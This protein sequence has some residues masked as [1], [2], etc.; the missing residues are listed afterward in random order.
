MKTCQNC[1]AENADEI[2]HCLA[3]H[4]EIIER[5]T[6]WQIIRETH[7]IRRLESK[8]QQGTHEIRSKQKPAAVDRTDESSVQTRPNAFVTA[9]ENLEWFFVSKDEKH[10]PVTAKEIQEKLKDGVLDQNAKIWSE[11]LP[12]WILVKNSEFASHCR[13]AGPSGPPP[14]DEVDESPSTLLHTAQTTGTV[15]VNENHADGSSTSKSHRR[16]IVIG[17]AVCLLLLGFLISRSAVAHRDLERIRREAPARIA[18]DEEWRL[19][20]Q[21]DWGLNAGKKMGEGALVTGILRARTEAEIEELGRAVWHRPFDQDFQRIIGPTIRQTG[22]DW[23][24]TSAQA[25]WLEAFVQGYREEIEK[26]KRRNTPLY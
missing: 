18:E 12:K 14:L 10:G 1:G 16:I 23:E 2:I 8:N 20:T 5:K 24:T 19:R 4:E 26:F 17:G 9:K 13:K 15:H 3:C 21:W 6:F 7:G 22:V 25:K 11:G